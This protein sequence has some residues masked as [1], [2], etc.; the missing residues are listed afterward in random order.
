LWSTSGVVPR[1]RINFFCATK[2]EAQQLQHVLNHN[3][4][5]I[6]LVETRA[7][8]RQRCS[9]QYLDALQG[10]SGLTSMFVDELPRFLTDPD[11]PGLLIRKIE[12]LG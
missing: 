7:E 2:D 10:G 8:V 1:V 5:G 3:V 9:V 4:S 12:F 6:T 11:R